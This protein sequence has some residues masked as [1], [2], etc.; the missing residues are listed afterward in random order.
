MY[1]EPKITIPNSRHLSL[2]SRYSYKTLIR[3]NQKNPQNRKLQ[4]CILVFWAYLPNELIP[5]PFHSSHPPNTHIKNDEKQFCYISPIEKVSNFHVKIENFFIRLHIH[6][7]FSYISFRRIYGKH[8]YVLTCPFLLWQ[9]K[10][11]Y[12]SHWV[13]LFFFLYFPLAPSPFI[14]KLILSIHLPMREKQQ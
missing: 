5:F 8:L 2:Y 6:T 7:Q 14:T 10:M 1:K 13:T 3:A 12:R 11:I 4:T 9:Q